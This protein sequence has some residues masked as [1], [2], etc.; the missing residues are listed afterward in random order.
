MRDDDTPHD[1]TPSHLAASPSAN[2]PDF[3]RYAGYLEGSGLSEE[4][5]AQFLHA[6][7]AILSGFVDLGFGVDSVNIAQLFQEKDGAP[8]Q[9]D[10]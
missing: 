7:W 5:T 1:Q 8:D 6:L 3:E 9:S 4:E 2:A 10:V